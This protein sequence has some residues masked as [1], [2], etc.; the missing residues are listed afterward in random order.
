MEEVLEA[1]RDFPAA[2]RLPEAV[3]ALPP[4]FLGAVFPEE[5]LFFPLVDVAML[6]IPFR[7]I[8]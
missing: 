2:L 3:A 7:I 5:V 8:G 1:L 4:L 6:D